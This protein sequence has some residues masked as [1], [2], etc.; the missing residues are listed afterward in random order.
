MKNKT[1]ELVFISSFLKNP[2]E[3]RE[4]KTEG[5][6]KKDRNVFYPLWQFDDENSNLDFS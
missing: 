5:K 4:K 3:A 1:V 2:S 6:K